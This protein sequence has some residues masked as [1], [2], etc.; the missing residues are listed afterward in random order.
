MPHSSL[1]KKWDFHYSRFA[2]ANPRGS[3]KPAPGQRPLKNFSPVLK[4]RVTTAI[5]AAI[6]RQNS[7]PPGLA[8]FHWQ[9]GYGAFSVSQHAP[10]IMFKFVPLLQEIVAAIVADLFDNFAVRDADFSNVRRVDDQFTL[11]S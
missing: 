11:V 1:T 2:H 4:G 7:H 8:G 9:N 5:H 10:R 3:N 6:A